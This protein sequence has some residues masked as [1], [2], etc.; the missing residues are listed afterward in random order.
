MNIANNKRKKE[1]QE[2]IEKIFVNMIQTKE[3][4]EITVKDICKEA[5]LN[6]STFYAN[7]LDVY[8][9]ADQIR[10]KLFQ[11]VYDLYNDERKQQYNKDGFL[12]LFYHIK[13]NHIFFKTYFKLGFDKTEIITDFDIIPIIN[14]FST[15]YLDYHVTFFKAGLNAIIVKWL[16][17]GCVE[18]PEE[19]LEIIKSEYKKQEL[20]K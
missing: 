9:L 16:N 11:D 12:K 3:I 8:D 14:D 18:T 2:K 10:K 20:F 13:E 19:M 4:N 6:R 7:Y 17:N 5:G 1:S 15:D